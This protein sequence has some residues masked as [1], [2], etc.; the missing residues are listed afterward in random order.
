MADNDNKL[1][2]GQRPRTASP[3]WFALP[4]PPPAELAIAGQPYRLTRVFKHDFFAATC[5]YERE[6]QPAGANQADASDQPAVWPRLV[7]KFYRAHGFLGVPL[8]W[9][10]RA[11]RN[12]ERAIYQALAGVQGLPRWVAEV[13]PTGYAI[14]YID[15]LP[16]DHHASTPLGFFDRLRGIFDAVHARGVAYVDG[17]KRS[18]ILLDQAGRPFLI[19]FQISLRRR[20]D[21]PWPLRWL[22]S[23]I[24]GYFQG[25]DLRFLYKHK[26]KLARSELTAEEEAIFRRKGLLH[27]LHDTLTRP[28]RRLRRA[29]LRRQHRRG[30]LVSPTAHLED[31]DQPEKRTWRGS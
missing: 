19:D 6:Q 1:P 24:V 7:V 16:L 5:L 17:N 10:G 23:R 14:E 11:S 25:K 27:W 9:L 31:H 20:D 28:Y 3:R 8:G 21:W 4:A 2:R 15:A 13:G 22:S 12:H 29:F 30:R 26:R 18:N